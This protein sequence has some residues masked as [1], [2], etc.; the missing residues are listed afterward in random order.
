MGDKVVWNTKYKI[1]NV[2]YV[3]RIYGYVVSVFRNFGVEMV[4]ILLF[5]KSCNFLGLGIRAD[6]IQAFS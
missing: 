3:D 2:E 5:K 1:N 6:S 4:F